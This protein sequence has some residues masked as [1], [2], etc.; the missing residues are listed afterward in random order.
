[1]TTEVTCNFDEN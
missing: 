1:M